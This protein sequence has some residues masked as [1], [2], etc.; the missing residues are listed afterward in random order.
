MMEAFTKG[1]VTAITSWIIFQAYFRNCFTEEKGS[2]KCLSSALTEDFSFQLP[3]FSVFYRQ[4]VLIQWMRN[5][6]FLL[7]FSTAWG[8]F[9][10]HCILTNPTFPSLLQWNPTAKKPIHISLIN[11]TK[12]PQAF[13]NR[14]E[15][16]CREHL[17]RG[18]A[19]S[20]QIPLFCALS[21]EKKNHLL[22]WL[23]FFRALFVL[24]WSLTQLFW[25][26][27]YWSCWPVL[28]AARQIGERNGW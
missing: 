2:R 19:A 16:I 13:R 17:E 9:F 6:T 15:N 11:N 28:L 14:A 24:L 10:V 5:Q 4:E 7:G 20:F 8:I 27:M 3:N 26:L 1:A 22:S 12:Y 21:W 23:C 18:D 25:A